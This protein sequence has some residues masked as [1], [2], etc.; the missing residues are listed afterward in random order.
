MQRSNIFDA[1][2]FHLSTLR[3]R[4]GLRGKLNILNL[5]LHCED[6]YAEF[7]NR[8]YSFQLGNMNAYVQNAEGID[9]LDKA[10]KLV[11]QVSATATKQ[12]VN[13]ALGKDLSIYK[14][15]QF[16]FMSIAEDA[17]PLRK[18]KYTNP[19][20]FVFD[21]AKD[22]YDVASILHDILHMGLAKQR[23]IYEFLRDQLSDPG[24]ERLMEESNL[25]SVINAIAKEDLEGSFGTSIAGDFNVDEKVAFNG[26]EA[27]AGV[28]EDYKVYNHIV[29][30]IYKEFDAGGVNKSRSVL[31]A[32]R[33]T[34]FKLS[35]KYSGDDLF[36]QIVEEV[37]TKVKES[38]NFARVPVEELHL[39]VNI[40][41]VDAFIRCKI[42]KKPLGAG[43]AHVAA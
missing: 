11:L 34:Y 29:D 2:E 4:V 27:A 20:G 32:F 14:G 16:R 22:I 25:A 24:A 12:K 31:D 17:E 40:L 42:F 9:L 6:F 33:M 30:R 35:P 7:L 41:A 8:L 19:H 18:K 21:P 37:T 23:E 10:G 28:I 26:L 36:F 39:C 5:H 1:C 13:A 15:Y 38:A 3:T 43:P